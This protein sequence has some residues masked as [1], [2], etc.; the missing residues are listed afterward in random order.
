[1]QKSFISA[2]LD[3]DASLPKGLKIWNGSDPAVRFAIY[4]NNVMTSLID[5]LADNFPVLQAQVG[6]E[7][8]RAMAAEFI[9]QH[10]PS[11]SVLAQY[12]QILPVWLTSFPPLADWPWLGDLARLE[13]TIINALNAPDDVRETAVLN[14]GFDPN[15]NGLVL[16][17]SLRVVASTYAIFHIWCSHQKESVETFNPYQAQNV[18]LFRQPE[19]IRI[20]PVSSAQANFVTNLQLGETLIASLE[21]MGDSSEELDVEQT[22]LVLRKYGLILNIKEIVC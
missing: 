12:G 17:S 5:A 3:P 10:P 16:D 14:Q 4:R 1:M 2:L 8:F 18:L 13:F 19:G 6:H 22:L 15:V 20:I 9:R 7:Y 21:R 11:S